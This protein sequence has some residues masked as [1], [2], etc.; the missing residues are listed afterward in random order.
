MLTKKD[1]SKV[2]IFL[3]AFPLIP[4]IICFVQSSSRGMFLVFP[5]VFLL[6]LFLLS[7]KR[8]LEY[9]LYTLFS[10][11]PSLLIYKFM[12]GGNENPG[13][14]TLTVSIV[15]FL[16]FVF[17][18]K[19]S[20]SRK[21][22]SV[23]FEKI[24]LRKVSKIII[25]VTIVIIGFLGFLDIKNEGI[26]FRQ[27]PSQLQ[28]RLNSTNIGAATA[29]ERLIF[30]NDGLKISSD[31]PI[32]GFGGEAWAAI[33]KK[34]QHMPY[35]SNKAHNGYLEWLIDTGWV[36]FIL[37]ISVSIYFFWLLFRNY[38]K[39]KENTLQVAVMV[40]TLGIFLHS[41]LDYNFSYS[42]IWLVII[43]LFVMGLDKTTGIKTIQDKK[44]VIF[45]GV[46]LIVF[47]IMMVL[48][49]FFSY[50][51]M[52]ADMLYT[53]FKQSKSLSFREETI[54]RAVSYDPENILYQR[55]LADTYFLKL[56]FENTPEAKQQLD[57]LIHDLTT[58]EP[59][60]STLQLKAGTLSEQAKDKRNALKYYSMGLKIDHYNKKL[61]ENSIRLKVT[62][63]I[64]NRKSGDKKGAEKLLQSAIKDYQDEKKWYDYFLT[65]AP[66]EAERFNSRDF[67]VT[68]RSHYFAALAYFLQKD[69]SEVEAISSTIKNNNEE[70][71]KV[72]ALEIMA[73]QT[74]GKLEEA[75]ALLDKYEKL[76]PLLQETIKNMEHLL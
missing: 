11:G 43:W 70:K 57:D 68:A 47:S 56:R 67:E 40:S 25:P 72:C 2:E 71:E 23:L 17:C 69:F 66:K 60:N 12:E 33:Y 32:I 37:F 34:Y 7:F 42:T 6:G 63:A 27:L 53:K 55:S 54:K 41:F 51:F 1:I 4:F 16:L 73:L 24:Q 76:F 39:Q 22:G 50:R 64:E 31:S 8:Q 3:Y 13:L 38:L 20:I 15:L 35:I 44:F 5:L 52:T 49:L 45:Q 9:I 59:S 36:G 75:Q 62:V 61:Y 58:L 14:V 19:Y 65:H 48:N 30:I 46:P 28:T 29:Q 18:I 74:D 21:A 10:F 26:I